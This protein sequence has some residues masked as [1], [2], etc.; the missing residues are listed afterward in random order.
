MI[1]FYVLFCL[2]KGIARCIDPKTLIRRKMSYVF[3]HSANIPCGVVQI[4]R[5]LEQR[6]AQRSIAAAPICYR[7]YPFNFRWR[8]ARPIPSILAAF[9]L[10]PRV[11]LSVVL[12][13]SLSISDKLRWKLC[14]EKRSFP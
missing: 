8:V 1:E 12:I 14:F 4:E 5:K 10:F 7:L 6:N 3:H 2:V 13:A 11:K 9:L